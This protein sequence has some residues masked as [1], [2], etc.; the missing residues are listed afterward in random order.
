MDWTALRP[1]QRTSV[2]LAVICRDSQG[3]RHLMQT[4]D[5]RGLKV[6]LEGEIPYGGTIVGVDLLVTSVSPMQFAVSRESVVVPVPVCDKGSLDQVIDLC[7][8]LGGFSCASSRVG[9][10]VQAGVDQNGLWRKLFQSFHKGAQFFVGDLVDPNVVR[11]LLSLGHFHCVLCSGVSCQPHSVLGDKRGMDDPRADS[12]PKTLN[13]AWLL[14]AAVVIIEC[15]PEVLRN[16]Q[17]QELLRQFTVNTG[18]R[19]FQTILKLSNA[20]CTRRDRWVAILTAPVIC[21][22]ELPDLPSCAEIRVIRDLIPAFTPWPQSEHDQLVLNLYELSKYYQYAAGGIDNAWLN[23]DDQLPTLLHSAG[24]QMYT[25]ACGCRAALSEARLK[26]KGLVGV[27]ILLPT[28]QTHM[29]IYMRHA[30]YLHPCE[31]WALMGGHPQA[32]MGH[33]LRLAMAGVGQ[34]VAP[35]MGLWI[36]AHVR[37]SLDLTFEVPPCD[38]TQ[39][40]KEY[41]AEIIQACRAKWP[42]LPAPTAPDPVDDDPIE[43]VTPWITLTWPCTDQ[44]D[45]KVKLTPHVTGQQLLDAERSLNVPVDGCSLRV[46]GEEFD[47]AQPLPPSSLVSIVP[48]GWHPSQLSATPVIPCCL[49]ADDFIRYVQTSDASDLGLVTDLQELRAIRVP[50]FSRAERLG[51]LTMQGPVWG[52]D[53]VLYGLLQTAIGTDTDQHVHVWDPLLVTGLLQ[54]ETTSTWSDLVAPLGPVATVVSAVLLGGHWIPLVWRVDMVGSQMHTVSVPSEYAPVMEKL[55]RVIEVLRGGA[56]GTWKEHSLGFSPSGHCGALV[57][58]FVRHLLWGWLLV[59]DQDW[60]AHYAGG[61]RG[62]FI[63]HLPDPCSRPCLAGLGFTVHQRLADLLL[64]HGVAASDTSARASAV[65][66]ALGEREVGTALESKN[67]WRELKWLGNQVRPPFMLIKPAE[68]QAQIDKRASDLPVGH[69]KHKHAKTPKGKGKGN[70]KPVVSLDPTLLRL[71]AGI[72]QSS[73]GVP[74]SQIGLSQ[75]GSSA[76]GVAVVSVQVI[77]P[78]LKAGPLSPGPLALFVVDAPEVPTTACSVSAERVPLVCCEF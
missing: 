55:A 56:R 59:T 38:P 27:L 10:A 51:L 77:E 22:C 18:Y 62:E 65:V 57:L 19:M 2:V 63:E 6:W 73:D 40:L 25:C 47:A 48:Q 72:F 46:D 30:R 75:V 69:K 60:L 20:W 58:S 13:I 8:G 12:L 37:R 16:A 4:Q 21:M 14:Q 44:P 61:M 15:T 17:A 76:S 1:G 71:E 26:S 64:S 24:N 41:M 5:R 3:T 53:E 39:V 28:C 36:F 74:M 35:L 29:N 42:P 33:N 70:S 54:C 11:Q 67:P 52:D 49:S 32:S 34:A 31:M 43:D 66:K 9:F 68:L 45:V 7:A 78:Y 50:S 23:M